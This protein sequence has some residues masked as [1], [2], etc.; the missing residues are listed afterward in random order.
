MGQ[1]LRGKCTAFLLTRAGSKSSREVSHRGMSASRR[2]DNSELTPNSLIV[3]LML[4]PV[5]VCIRIFSKSERN[6]SGLSPR[7]KQFDEESRRVHYD[8]SLT[9][10]ARNAAQVAEVPGIYRVDCRR[11]RSGLQVAPVCREGAYGS[12]VLQVTPVGCQV[13]ANIRSSRQAQHCAR[14][15]ARQRSL[16]NC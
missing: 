1:M 12:R 9:C 7:E 2:L 14:H 5:I 13:R 3:F 4:R 15:E 10:R 8:S 16:H 6:P 11:L